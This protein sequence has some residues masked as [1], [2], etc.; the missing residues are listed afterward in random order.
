[1]KAFLGTLHRPSGSLT[2]TSKHTTTAVTVNEFEPR[3]MEDLRL[4]LARKAPAHDMYMHNDLDQRETPGAATYAQA[5]DKF[6]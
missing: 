2:V 4:W 5:L 3:L 6:C 1:M